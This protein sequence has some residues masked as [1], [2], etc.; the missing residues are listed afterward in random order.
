MMFMNWKMDIF[1]RTKPFK[2]TANSGKVGARLVMLTASVLLSACSLFPKEEE[3][4]APPLVEPAPVKYEVAKV[5]R[6]TITKGVSGSSTFTT[7][8]RFELSFK[9]PTERLKSFEVKVGDQVKRGQVLAELDAGEIELQI[10]TAEYE[11]REAQLELKAEQLQ[12]TYDLDAAK[13]D[14]Q[15]AEMTAKVAETKLASLEL[16]KARL[17]VKELQDTQK[18]AYMIEKAKLNV[19]EKELKLSTLQKK[20]EETRLVSPVDGE[21]VFVS[22]ESVGDRIE[23]NQALLAIADPKKMMI[24]Y[25]APTEEHLKEVEVGMKANLIAMDHPNLVGKVVQTPNSLPSNLNTIQAQ[26]HATTLVIALE[27]IPD[28]IKLGTPVQFQIVLAQQSNALII[29]IQALRAFDKREYVVVLEGK[30][31]REI[32]VETGIKTATEVE[33]VKGLQEGQLVILE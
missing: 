20:W 16:E 32:D 3:V 29:P 9:E 21:V 31:K 19:M 1:K 11:L 4:L 23:A 22:N 7:T 2:A 12:S 30:T 14:L 25:Q 27:K 8:D 28:T 26:N 5:E 17:R 15:K 6:G 24:R 13:I 33:I 18:Q 10:Q